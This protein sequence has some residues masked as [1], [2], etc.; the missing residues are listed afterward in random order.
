MRVLKKKI[1]APVCMSHL[2]DIYNSLKLKSSAQS[3]RRRNFYNM[4]YK[5]EKDFQTNDQKR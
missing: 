2:E 1:R 4:H 3:F 5:A